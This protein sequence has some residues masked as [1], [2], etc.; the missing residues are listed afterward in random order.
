MARKIKKGLPPWMGT[1]ADLAT[2]LLTFFVLLL[3]FA[4]MDMVKFQEMLGSVQNAFGV[5]FNIRGQF[6]PTKP[7][8]PAKP[9]TTQHKKTS[10]SLTAFSRPSASLTSASEA[11]D[12]AE[13]ASQAREIQKELN[14]AGMSKAVD[15]SSGPGGV[16][17]RVKGKLLFKPGQAII[18]ADARRLLEAVAKVSLK[19]K[20]Y[21]TVEGHTDSQPIRTAQFP[22]NWELSSSRAAAVLRF[23]IQLGVPEAKVSAVGYAANYPIASNDTAEGREKNRRVEFIFA[24]KPLRSRVR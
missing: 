16:R 12:A 15:V 5:Q 24:K 10:S 8:A 11:R 7:T 18:K 17:M 2:L 4:N 20:Y 19:F 9:T 21:L 6:Q 23:L 22:S 14:Q 3:T 1:F 13:S